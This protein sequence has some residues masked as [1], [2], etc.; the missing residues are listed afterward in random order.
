MAVEV[1]GTMIRI[2]QG[3]TGLVR[4]MAD[5]GEI[6]QGDTAVFTLAHRGGA[7]ILRKVLEADMEQQAFTMMFVHED[8]ARLRPDHY[9]WSLRI[10]RSG[11]FDA[12][13]R[14]LDAKGQHTAVLSGRLSVL[15]YAGGVR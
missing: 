13:G 8:T 9:E 12:D 2:P 3:D 5:K 14:L 11:K 6:E 4:F 7:A 10:V 15:G 1:S